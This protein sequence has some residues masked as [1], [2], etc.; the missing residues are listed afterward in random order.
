MND[1]ISVLRQQPAILLSVAAIFGLLVGSFLN[2]VIHRLPKM[3]ERDWR[4]Q[5]VEF[6]GVECAAKDGLPDNYGLVHPRSNC[7]HCGHTIGALENIPVISYLIQRGRCKHCR[8]SIALRYP[9]IE[10]ASALLVA[11]VAW[12]YGFAWQTLAAALLSWA[13][14]VLS[15]ID[16]DHQL[17]PDS[18]TLP[19]LWLGIAVNLLG[20][21]TDLQSSVIGAMA[22][23]LSLWSVYQGFRILTGKEGMGF[24]DFKLLAMLGAWQGWQYLPAIIVLSSMVGAVAGLSLMLLRGHDRNKPIPFG[25]YLAAAGW[26]SLI[27]GA[28]INKTYLG[29]V[30]P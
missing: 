16:L 26:I 25:P 9:L 8:K 18:I 7:P 14:L 19:F 2:V 1:L 22:G 27:W 11:V 15:L 13:L 17:L 23:Y 10:L 29:W 6:L 5:C 28:A 20:L 3:M 4:Q 30:L 24:G 12:R 21:F